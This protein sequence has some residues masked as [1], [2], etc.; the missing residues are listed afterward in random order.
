MMTGL[1]RV[2]LL[3]MGSLGMVGL[4]LGVMQT[5]A[6]EAAPTA[7]CTVRVNSTNTNYGD[8][9]SAINNANPSGDLLKVAGDCVG[10]TTV[11][12]SGQ[13]GYITQPL[14]LRG[15]YTTTNWVTSDPI[16]NPTTLDA[17]STGRVLVISPTVSSAITVENLNLTG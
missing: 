10:T 8:L 16:A 3:V 1:K 17:D 4:L 9:Q 15:G 14:T 5:T 11:N 2:L 13:V 7:A 6:V 12:G